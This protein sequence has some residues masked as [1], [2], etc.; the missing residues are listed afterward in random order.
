MHNKEDTAIKIAHL[1][2]F[3]HL[4][5]LLREDT[6]AEESTL[7]VISNTDAVCSQIEALELL[8][9][10]QLGVGVEKTEGRMTREEG[11]I[12]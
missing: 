5:R 12:V 3:N 9:D 8:E 2:F 7:P 11:A 10:V 4:A 6:S 1:L